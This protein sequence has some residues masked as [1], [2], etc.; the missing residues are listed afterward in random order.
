MRVCMILEGCYPFVR[1]GVSAWIHQYLTCSPEIEFILWTI[2][3]TREDA[4]VPLYQFP[5]NVKEHHMVFLDEPESFHVN[6]SNNHAVENSLVDV[7]YRV[8]NS[9]SDSLDDLAKA[10]RGMKVSPLRLL[11]SEALLKVAQKL[12]DETPGLGLSDAFFSL[13]SMLLPILTVLTAKIP[14]ADLYHSAVTGYGGLLG[15]MAAIETN[16]P[17][18]LT[19]HGI[20]PREREE[21]LISSDWTVPSMRPRWISLFYEMS[22]FAYKYASRVT[23]LF[24]DA[25]A[26]Q[27]IIGCDSSKCV[28]VPN[29]IMVDKFSLIEPPRSSDEI[30]IGAFVRFAAIKDLKTLI[31]AFSIAR[32]T[33]DNLVLH[34]MGSTDDQNYRDSCESLIDRLELNQYVII[35]GH[36]DTLEYMRK[37]HLTI[38]TS[39]SEGQPLT[40]LESMASGRPCIATRVGNCVGLIEEEID[41]IGPAGI[42]CTPM[43][44]KEIAEAIVS[45]CSDDQLRLR[46]GSN[47][48][49]RVN[50]RYLLQNMLNSYH[51]VYREVL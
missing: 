50:T 31:H 7:I 51:S 23:S 9:Q 42:C 47:G 38:L 13:Q 22:K 2:H 34:I 49:K 18:V 35:E 43:V 46:M 44:S 17:F 10:M 16:K 29:G 12:S 6:H 48:K 14:E 24:E 20:Y 4:L 19:E 25:K 27:I 21:E 30:H 11:H 8:A 45:L 3:A 37:M 28:V 36:V 5:E 41:G 40:I 33:K 39:I 15:A 1:G 26:R 32:R